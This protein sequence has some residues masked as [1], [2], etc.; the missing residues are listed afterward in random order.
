MGARGMGSQGM[1]S[2]MGSQS[3]ESYAGRGPKGYKRS[4]E[5][6]RDDASDRLEQDHQVDASEI[7]IEVSEGAPLGVAVDAAARPGGRGCFG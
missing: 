1:G 4:D 6:V 7:S 3:Q 5:R 2:Q